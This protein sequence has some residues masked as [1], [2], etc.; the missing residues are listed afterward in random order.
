M[1][2]DVQSKDQ[3][4]EDILIWTLSAFA[5]L[6]HVLFDGLLLFLIIFGG[7]VIA[8]SVYQQKLVLL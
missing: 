2:R 5:S 3:G 6:P 8:I 4:E 7:A 1:I